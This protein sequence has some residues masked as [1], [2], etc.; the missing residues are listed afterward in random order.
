MKKFPCVLFVTFVI[1]LWSIF[2]KTGIT[3]RETV[4]EVNMSNIPDNT[5]FVEL[6]VEESVL[7]D[8]YTKCNETAVK[9][10]NISP[11]AEIVTTKFDDFISYTYHHKNSS[12][13]SNLNNRK[14]IYNEDID[15]EVVYVVFWDGIEKKSVEKYNALMIAYVDEF[16]QILEKS[17]VVYINKLM[18]KSY[19]I[20][21]GEEITV[22]YNNVKT[23]VKLVL[24]L[25]LVLIESVLFFVLRKKKDR[26][27][28]TGDGSLC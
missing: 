10:N 5:V 2:S 21:D 25:S 20:V 17:D 23:P 1:F 26:K 8:N 27:D 14:T 16:G 15:N 13:L 12:S 22:K 28:D 18:E 4:C 6:F 9:Q 7:S 11:E 19:L 3:S 24:F